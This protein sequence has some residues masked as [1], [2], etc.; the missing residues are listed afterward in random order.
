MGRQVVA[1]EWMHSN[2]AKKKAHTIMVT[3]NL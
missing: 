2:L 3:L 1:Y